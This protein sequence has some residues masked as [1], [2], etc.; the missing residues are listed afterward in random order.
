M[1]RIKPP[2]FRKLPLLLAMSAAAMALPPLALAAILEEIIV[3]AT[4]RSESAQDIPMSIQAVT[5]DT[6][7]SQGI[8]D[9][10]GLSESIPNFYV[11]L[12]TLGPQ[13]G[14]RGMGSGNNRGFEQSVAMF[15]DGVYKPRTLQYKAS[16]LDLDRVEVLRGPQAVMF[17]L[18]A[19]AGSVSI[20]SSTNQP[21]DEFEMEI[22]GEYEME[23]KGVTSTMVIGGSPSETLGLRLVYRNVAGDEG[24]YDNTATG[25]SED[26]VDSDMVRLSAVWDPADELT[27]T[28]K[29]AHSDYEFEGGNGELF[30]PGAAGLDGDGRLN[31]R[32]QAE[33]TDIPTITGDDFIGIKMQ[34]DNLSINIDYALGEHTLTA[35]LGYSEFDYEHNLDFDN[36]AAPFADA[37]LIHEYEQSSAE[38][39]WASPENSDIAFVAGLYYQTSENTLDRN[40]LVLRFVTI[41]EQS[42]TETDMVSVFGSATWHMSDDLRLTGG[43]RY[44]DEDREVGFEP[45]PCNIIFTGAETCDARSLVGGEHN[46]KN[47]MPEVIVQWDANNDIMLYGKVGTSAKAGGFTSEGEEFGDEKVLGFELGMKASLLDGSA[48]LN[49]ALFRNEFEDL[50]VNSFIPHPTIPNN[51]LTVVNNAGSSVNQGVEVDGRWAITEWL[52][53]RGAVAYLDAEYDEFENGPCPG[54]AP[55][56]TPCSLSGET[57]PWTAEYSGNLGLDFR[58]AVND[59][60]EFFFSPQ[61][62]FSGEY[63]T[64][65]PLDPVDLQD[66]WTKVSASLGVE[67]TEDRWSVS[68]IGKNLTN[69][70]ILTTSQPFAFRYVGFISHPRTVALQGKYRF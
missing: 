21:G 65:G 10:E 45:A 3:T 48:Q 28:S 46:S 47:A 29:Y 43:V 22:T 23:Y 38:L 4:K 42:V 44:V 5:G 8:T 58:F 69:E 51:L 55:P 20:I 11:G 52:T 35:L 32:R 30:G 24:F 16:F 18:N 15:V 7:E 27:I 63:H 62:S 31:W 19:T 57:L 68:L 2:R 56:T 25:E 50:Q 6:L 64:N 60:V 61:V 12:G 37:Y 40:A 70:V 14:M 39:R 67:S 49:V 34:S 17:G 66:S 36:T 59:A 41:G 1:T 9:L 54:L 33:A 53:L 26:I 13:I